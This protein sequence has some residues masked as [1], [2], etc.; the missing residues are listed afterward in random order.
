MT[1]REPAANAIREPAGLDPRLVVQ[2]IA[3]CG[4]SGCLATCIISRRWM[5]RLSRSLK[6]G[7]GRRGGSLLAS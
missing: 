4:G 2:D 1:V 6:W 5:R 3:E 7:K